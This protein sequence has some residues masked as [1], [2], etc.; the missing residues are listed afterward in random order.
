MKPK[1]MTQDELLEYVLGNID[2]KLKTKW[3]K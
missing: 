1:D 3:N 2:D